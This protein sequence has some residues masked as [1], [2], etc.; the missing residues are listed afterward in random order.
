MTMIGTPALQIAHTHSRRCIRDAGVVKAVHMQV[1]ALN[2][3]CAELSRALYKIHKA[4]AAL[5]LDPGL[6]ARLQQQIDPCLVGLQTPTS[7]QD[8]ANGPQH[9]SAK[10]SCHAVQSSLRLHGLL[11]L[12]FICVHLLYTGGCKMLLAEDCALYGGLPTFD[13]IEI[14]EDAS[15]RPTGSSDHIAT[16]EKPT[17]GPRK[18]GRRYHRT[19]A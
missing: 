14:K 13:I 1:H 9:A 3:I 16:D 2:A 6:R 19:S 11:H 8:H 5:D 7:Q 12:D 15:S 4:A 18:S 10:A 17:P